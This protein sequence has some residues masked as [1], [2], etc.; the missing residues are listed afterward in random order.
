MTAE[1]AQRQMDDAEL[2]DTALNLN[3]VLGDGSRDSGGYEQETALTSAVPTLVQL[4]NEITHQYEITYM[5]P[6]G[7][8]P[9]G[10]LQVLTKR[11]NVTLRAPQKVPN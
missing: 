3:L 11:K 9:S 4:A 6:A 7:P 10:R 5:L 1:A 8:S 2:A